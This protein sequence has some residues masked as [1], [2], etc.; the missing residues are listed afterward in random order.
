MNNM[1]GT[2]KTF[3]DSLTSLN[4][5]AIARKFMMIALSIDKM[6]MSVE[7]LGAGSI[8]KL[9]L[10]KAFVHIAQASEPSTTRRY[11]RF[12][13][14]NRINHFRGSVPTTNMVG[15]NSAGPNYI[16][17]PKHNG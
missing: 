13:S 11:G 1:G 12:I 16:I 6:R 2:L 4:A 7:N 8:A 10:L 3:E 15:R 17:K 14:K 5:E 9:M